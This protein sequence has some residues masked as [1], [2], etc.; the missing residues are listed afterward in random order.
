MS[1]Q[2]KY[3]KQELEDDAREFTSIRR[4]ALYMAKVANIVTEITSGEPSI[5]RSG[6]AKLDTYHD[7]QASVYAELQKLEHFD[8]LKTLIDDVKYNLDHAIDS[9]AVIDLPTTQNTARASARG[10]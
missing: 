6:V 5:V 8:S 7:V 1:A 2:Y 9:D 10:Y 4:T 3:Y